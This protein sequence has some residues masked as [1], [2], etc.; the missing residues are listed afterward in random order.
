MDFCA[1]VW[2]CWDCPAVDVAWLAAHAKNRTMQ[3]ERRYVLKTVFSRVTYTAP[4]CRSVSCKSVKC[5]SVWHTHVSPSHKIED[6]TTAHQHQRNGKIHVPAIS[7]W[8]NNPTNTAKLTAYIAAQ[9]GCSGG[10]GPQCSCSNAAKIFPRATGN[11]MSVLI[12]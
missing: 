2:V 12:V 3:C 11:L 1:C 7:P 8:S 9:P 6:N 4:A 10:T 5:A